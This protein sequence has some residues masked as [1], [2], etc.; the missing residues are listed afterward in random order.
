MGFLRLHKFLSAAGVCSR[1]RAERHILEGEV[2]VN[3]QTVLELGTSVD[4]DTDKVEFQGRQVTPAQS[5]VYVALNKPKGYVTSCDHPGEKIVLD[6]VKTPYR[7]FPI[8]RLDKDST[9][10]ILLTNDGAIHHRL[11]H[12]SFDHEK[13][14][15]VGVDGPISD[16]A[17]QRLEKGVRLQEGMTRPAQVERLSDTAF[18][19][20]LKEGR[21]RQIRRMVR[22]LGLR[23]RALKRTRFA[24]IDLGDLPP[25]KWRYLNAQ[26]RDRLIGQAMGA[27]PNRPNHG[28]SAQMRSKTKRTRSATFKTGTRIKA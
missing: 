18:R 19:I 11:L 4:P 7:L 20:I 25:G 10:L 16:E 13:T 9:G 8:G 3:G 27:E 23:V 12:P 22:V 17:L 28:D 15:E 6:L 5:L 2:K 21:N 14:Y 24:G 26:E 1:R